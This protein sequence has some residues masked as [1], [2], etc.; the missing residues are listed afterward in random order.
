MA[1][2]LGVRS[3]RPIQFGYFHI[4][5]AE[6]RTEQGRLYLLVAI[7]RTSKFAFVQVHEK[8]TQRVA[9]DFLKALL[10]AV[11]YKIHTVLT[12]NGVHFTTP[13]NRCSAAAE[14][15]LALQLGELFRSRLRVRLRQ[16]RYRPPTPDRNTPGPTARSGAPA[17]RSS[18]VRWRSNA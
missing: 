2:S 8:A 17:D 1:I 13:G 7:D 15:K 11:P 9:A 10:E 14:I 16:S 3:S 5:I 18:S 6:V 12:D 4:D